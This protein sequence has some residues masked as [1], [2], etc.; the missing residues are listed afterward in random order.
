MTIALQTLNPSWEEEFIFRVQ[1]TQHKLVLQVFD[2]NRL[3]RD[4]FLGMIEIPLPS[5]PK[6][7]DNHVIPPKKLNLQP[8]STRSKVKG[9]LTVYAAFIPDPSDPSDIPNGNSSVTQTVGSAAMQ[10]L[11]LNSQST[12]SGNRYKHCLKNS[13]NTRQLN[14]HNPIMILVNQLPMVA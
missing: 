8:R 14:D 4:D 10:A 12:G 7:A 13:L 1:Q 11:D 5:L 2:E 6:E 9:Y 3:T